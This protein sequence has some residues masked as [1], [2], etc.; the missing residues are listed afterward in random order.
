M[1][2]IATLRSFV[3]QQPDQP[4]PLYALALEHKKLGQLAEARAA[5]EQM[6]AR[7]PDYLPT[8]LMA[9]GVLVELGDRAAAESVYRDGITRARAA[10]D[11]HAR[12]ELEGALAHLGD[13]G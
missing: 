6:I 13:P 7:F 5:F 10:G 3:A 1:D 12:S 4:F 2:R 8:Y 11:G 9:G